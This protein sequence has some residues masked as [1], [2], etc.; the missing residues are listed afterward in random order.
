MNLERRAPRALSGD[1]SEH[2]CQGRRKPGGAVLLFTLK[3]SLA[4]CFVR[5]CYSP[6]PKLLARTLIPLTT[7]A[8]AIV[9]M[10]D[11]KARI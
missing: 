2:G 6:L 10:A 3:V 4:P 11:T 8:I 5:T 7:I 1:G 9:G